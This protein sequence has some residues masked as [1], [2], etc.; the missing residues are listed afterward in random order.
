MEIFEMLGSSGAD[1]LA[2]GSILLFLVIYGVAGIAGLVLYLL[3]AI[4]LYKMGKSL[5]ACAPW[6]SFIPIASTFAFGRIASKYVKKDGKNSA[7]FGVWLLILEIL[8]YA[9]LIALIV[10]LV[11]ALIAV[12]GYADN[13]AADHSAMTLDMFSA[14]IPV[15]VLYVALL[16]IAVTYEI[17]Y[18]VALWR[19]FSIFSASNATLFTV[20]SIFFTFLFPIFIFAVRNARPTLTYAERL[21][22]EKL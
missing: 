10:F 22:F 11:I 16:G 14:F 13:A 2:G 5:G 4:G 21:G 1:E 20:L 3:Q 9:L 6:I 19:I 17:L 15:I 12:A 7:N 18:F 8:M